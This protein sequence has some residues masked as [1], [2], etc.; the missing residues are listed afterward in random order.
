MNKKIAIILLL[1]SVIV[2]LIINYNIYRYIKIHFDDDSE[3]IKNY[4]NLNKCQDCR[5]VIS[6][7]TV[8]ERIKLLKPVI[9]SLLDQ[10]VKVDQI[11]LNIP[12]MCKEK[13]YD[14][15]E[16]LNNM[17]NVF[18]CG[19]DY[20]PG[21]KFFP[22][23][24]REQETNTI[25]IMLDDDYIYGYDFIETLLNEYEKEPDSAIIMNEAMLI[26]PEF[27]DTS[28]LYTNKKY[29]DN[30]WIKKYI[31]SKKKYMNYGNNLRTFMM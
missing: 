20:G 25:I 3:Y 10:S 4:K 11:V 26:K 8:P 17:C 12:K 1:F 19:R 15:P 22:T 9:K 14:V 6:L 5:I 18:T 29:I 27:I 28:V 24:L 2:F 21:T 30:E 16:E 31:N 13:P 23:I 7:T